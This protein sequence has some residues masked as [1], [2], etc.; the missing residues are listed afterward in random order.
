MK[1]TYELLLSAAAKRDLKRL[2]SDIQHAVVFEHLPKI[3]QDTFLVGTPLLGALKGELS[4]HFGRK[5]EYRIIYFLEDQLIV[6]TI[7]ASLENIYNR[8]K[9]RLS[10]A[11]KG[12][13]SRKREKNREKI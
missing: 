9:R 11:T 12:K 4:Y 3:A 5:P 6:V 1:K 13:K 2:V 8:A 10:G 7:I